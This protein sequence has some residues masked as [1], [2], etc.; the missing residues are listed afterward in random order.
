[1]KVRIRR[2]TSREEWLIQRGENGNA[3]ESPG[4]L[5]LDKYHTP[6][7]LYHAKKRVEITPDN[8]VLRRGRWY[9]PMV[10][11]AIQERHPDW[12]ITRC[13]DYFDIPAARIGCTPDAIVTDP[14][15][16][17]FGYLE[18]KTVSPA[19]FREDWL[20]E[21]GV[22][23]TPV[24]HQVQTIHGSNIVPDITWACVG[25]GVIDAH[26]PVVHDIEVPIH[27]EPATKVWDRIQIAWADFWAYFDADIEPPVSDFDGDLIRRLYPQ[28][29]GDAIDLSADNEIR[30]WL[31]RRAEI[32]ARVAPLAKQVRAI[33]KEREPY[34]TKIK[35]K[36]GEAPGAV[37]PGYLI[38]FINEPRAASNPR[39][40][41]IK[42]VF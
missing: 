33:E 23:E 35:A 25:V 15:R 30:E 27:S 28:A 22:V 41:R 12:T 6:L 39:V 16:A 34:D 24:K 21:D 7:A 3:S 10:I 20:T 31:E 8:G 17:G 19:V 32:N 11:E 29:I 26:N 13:Q 2:K 1:M 14:A 37:L 38:K 40:L 5:G 18:I 36:L 9:E 4:L 42:E